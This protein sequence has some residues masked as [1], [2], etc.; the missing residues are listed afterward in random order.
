MT[1][2]KSISNN[3]NTA[4]P[5]KG[6]NHPFPTPSSAVIL[7]QH[8]AK[9]L[10]VEVNTRCFS[11]QSAVDGARLAFVCPADYPGVLPLSRKWRERH[12]PLTVMTNVGMRL[13]SEL[14][15]VIGVAIIIDT[16]VQTKT[17]LLWKSRRHC[18]AQFC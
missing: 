16:C 5:A 10:T 13:S 18:S 17:C 4:P 12:R 7:A 1:T 14:A 8:S 15:N 3:K 11:L 2:P 6:V 9:S